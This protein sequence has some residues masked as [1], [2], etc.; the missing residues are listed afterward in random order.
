MWSVRT[1]CR[2]WLGYR[3][4]R[5]SRFCFLRFGAEVSAAHTWNRRSNLQCGDC[6]R[7]SRPETFNSIY[8]QNI[9]K[10]VGYQALQREI[11]S[12]GPKLTELRGN[13]GARIVGTCR[14]CRVGL[15]ES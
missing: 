12:R 1:A 14:K 3:G 5:H 4:G 15:M 6:I 10:S 13:C 7:L 11:E 2:L 8:E 9:T